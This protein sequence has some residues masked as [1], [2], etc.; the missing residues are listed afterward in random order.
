MLVALI[1]F[2]D[3]FRAKGDPGSLQQAIAFVPL[4]LLGVFVFASITLFAE[5][6]RIE[7]G[8]SFWGNV[9][10]TFKG[11]VGLDGP[12]T[13]N[14]EVFADFF[15]I[16]LLVLGVAGL[17]ILLYLVLRTFVQAEPPSSERRAQAERIVRRWGDDTLDYFALRRDKNYF[18]SRRRPVAD[19]LPLRARHGDGRRRPDRPARA[20]PPARSTSSSA[21][22]P[23]T[24]GGSPSSPS[25]RPTPRSTASA[26]CTR[27]TSATR[28]SSTPTSSA[29]RG[30]IARR[31]APPSSTSAGTTSSS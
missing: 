3:E 20:T 15:E 2:R 29:S 5:R 25:A 9:E 24:A 14:R 27:S 7:P 30:P 23:S 12:Y 4:Y 8:L 11:M 21:S 1:W 18:F 13:Y 28:R 26:A 22:A 10:T 6:D 19:R 16:S 31:S 17:L